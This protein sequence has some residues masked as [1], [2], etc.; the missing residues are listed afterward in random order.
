MAAADA[1]AGIA[2]SAD[3]PR[4]RLMFDGLM[5]YYHE[6]LSET[7]CFTTHTEDVAQVRQ[8]MRERE[9][10]VRSLLGVLELIK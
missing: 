6:A 3:Y 8:I 2:F 5:R 9:S 10:V 7:A 4:L 1:T